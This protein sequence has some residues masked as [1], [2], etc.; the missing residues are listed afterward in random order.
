M[1][2]TGPFAVGDRVQLTDAKGRHYSVLLS[3]GGEFHTHRGAIAH[4]AVIGLPEGS[5]VKS[6][7]GDQFLALRPLLVDYVM[8]MPRGAQ[9]VYPK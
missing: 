6:T 7:N 8:S 4:D 3:P 5:V 1:S 9:V 2:A